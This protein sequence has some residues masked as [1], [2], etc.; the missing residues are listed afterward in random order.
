VVAQPAHADIGSAVPPI[1]RAAAQPNGQIGAA[2][3]SVEHAL[4]DPGKPLETPAAAGHERRFGHDFSRVRVHT[5][6]AAEQSARD[7]DAHAYTIGHDMV[8]AAGQFAP[9][10]HQGRRLIAHELTHVVQ[11]SRAVSPSP[12]L[13]QRTPDDKPPKKT[14]KSDGVD[15]R[16]P[17]AQSTA[18]IIDA[19][20]ARNQKLA[21]HIRDRL[22]GGLKIAEKGSFVQDSTDA[23]FDAAYRKAYELSSADTVSKD[24]KGFFDPKTSEIHLRPYAQFGTALH[25]AVH[26][27]VTGSV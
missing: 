10:T 8:F 15:P 26:R 20:L 21:Q 13:I 25:E 2:P 5:G 18:G 3:A 12:T 16:D 22:K 7:V 24:T 1:Q 23:N 27:L 17:V 14:P 19:V 6:T 4:A 11:Q 9:H